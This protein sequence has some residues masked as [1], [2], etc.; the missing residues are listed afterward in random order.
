MA[1][2]FIFRNTSFT[3]T[4]TVTIEFCYLIFIALDFYSI[5]YIVIPSLLHR[6]KYL[7]FCIVT[8]A[9]IFVSALARTGVAS[10]MNEHVFL[11]GNNQPA[12][13]RVLL[14]SFIN[15]FIWVQAITWARLAWDKV[16]SRQHLAAVEKENTQH[17]LNFLKAQVNPHFLFNSLNSIYGHI[18]RNNK[19]A[20]NILV[21]F[22]EMLRYQLYECSADKVNMGKELQYIRNYVTLQQYRKEEDLVVDLSLD[23]TLSQLDIAPLL[24]IVFI[25]NAFKYVSSFEQKENK[26]VISLARQNNTLQCYVFNTVDS[27]GSHTFESHGGIGISNV[28]RRL[29][30]LYPGK[31]RLQIAGN[32]NTYEV[33]LQIDLS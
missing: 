16:K 18:D 20:R 2:I 10:F 14:N 24:L 30:I 8:L 22:S 23:E 5:S 12:F 29:E 21:K 3:L 11:A 32:E 27:H 26:I 1:W 15:I 19:T 7:L 25:E 31:H 13:G 9:I 33:N 28:K 4:K 6:K 17:E